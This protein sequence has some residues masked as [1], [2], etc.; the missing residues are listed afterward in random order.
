MILRPPNQTFDVLAAPLPPR[1]I[2]TSI[3]LPSQTQC[4]SI[5]SMAQAIGRILLLFLLIIGLCTVFDDTIGDGAL[6]QFNAL[7]II[8][9][10]LATQA[11]QNTT[12]TFTTHPTASDAWQAMGPSRDLLIALSPEIAAWVY[13][14]HQEH[15]IIYTTPTD[16]YATYGIASNTP[17]L[18]AYR[19]MDGK[20]YIGHAFWT[21]SDGQKVVVLTH[22]YRHYRQN[23]PKRISHMLAQLLGGGQLHYE[24]RIEDEAFSYEHQAQAALGI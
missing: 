20:L 21:L 7:N 1:S 18:A 23:A 8:A 16:A 19:H 3:P 15:R 14:M 2:R 22:E 10:K 4:F 5:Q 12:A 11:K 24:S 9:P 17:L 6:P 13:Q